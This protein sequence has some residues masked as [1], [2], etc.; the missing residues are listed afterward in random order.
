MTPQTAIVRP[1][2]QKAALGDL[3]FKGFHERPPNH[4]TRPAR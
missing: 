2:L 4:V 3:L 1:N